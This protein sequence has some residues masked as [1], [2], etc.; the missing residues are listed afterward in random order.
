MRMVWLMGTLA[1]AMCMNALAGDL[2]DVQRRGALT[3]G[4]YKEFPP[5]FD[6]G[7]GIDV[8]MAQALAKKLG[9]RAELQ[10][11]DAGDNMDDDLR[12]MVWKGSP[13]ALGLP[14]ADVMLHVPIDAV[15]M[16]RNPRVRIFS[17]YYRE[18]LAV[19]RSTEALPALDSMMSAEG[20][21]I[22]AEADSIT[23][24]ALL[25]Y[26]GGRLGGTVKHY[27]HIDAAPADLKSGAIAAFFGL[28]SQVEPMQAA[29]GR[30]FKMSVPP[31]MPGLPQAGWAQ[32]L[33]VSTEHE[34]LAQA[35]QR[36]VN[37][38]EQDGSLDRIFRAH[39]VTRLKPL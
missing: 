20:K 30:D 3:V 5:F 25:A 15:F 14:P 32:G 16:E 38:L 10:A 21:A 18:T 35:L 37:E 2:A 34:A 19:L 11:Y 31:P 33:A 12:I 9:V 23:D 36:A 7:Q 17:P 24:M 29:A 28:R 27:L 6:G 4:V 22:G 8:D 26:D 1:C 39:G 13:T